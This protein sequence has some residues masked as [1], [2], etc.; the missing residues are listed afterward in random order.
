MQQILEKIIEL[1]T[2][3]KLNSFINGRTVSITRD[4]EEDK[5]HFGKEIS[6]KEQAA[7]AID[8]AASELKAF[9]SQVWEDGRQFD[10]I[11]LTGGGSL[12]LGN[13]LRHMYPNVIELM[14]PVTANARGLARFAQRKGILDPAIQVASRVSQAKGSV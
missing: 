5:L 8:V 9:L 7:Q 12:I 10:Y 2:P 4:N 11:L 13:R 6:L 14:D 3:L 1:K